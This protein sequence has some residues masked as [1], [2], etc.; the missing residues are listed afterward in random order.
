MIELTLSVTTS[1]ST[2]QCANAILTY[3]AS[4]PLGISRVIIPYT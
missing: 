3:E 2:V 4:M 1:K